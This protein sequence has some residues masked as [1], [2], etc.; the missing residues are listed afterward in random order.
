MAKLPAAT[1]RVSGAE[2]FKKPVI[3][4][5]N[6]VV[7]ISHKIRFV[8]MRRIKRNFVADQFDTSA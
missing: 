3:S 6:C 4:V 8:E 7:L 2:T 1:I 5:F